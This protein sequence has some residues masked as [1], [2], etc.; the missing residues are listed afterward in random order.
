MSLGALLLAPHR[1]K[2]SAASAPHRVPGG[3]FDHRGLPGVLLPS[4]TGAVAAR[5]ALHHHGARLERDQRGAD[6]RDGR[7]MSSDRKRGLALNSR[8]ERRHGRRAASSA[9][10]LLAVAIPELGFARPSGCWSPSDRCWP[11]AVALFVRAEGQSQQADDGAAEPAGAA[12][13]LACWS[14]SAPLQPSCCCPR[15]FLTHLVPLASAPRHGRRAGDRPPPLL[16]A[17]TPW[18]ALVGTRWC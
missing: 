11:L 2:R 9:P 8:A 12:A 15:V 14:I 17:S 3:P 7:A 13:P 6:R 5:R 16:S 1:R 10:V 18:M 4:V